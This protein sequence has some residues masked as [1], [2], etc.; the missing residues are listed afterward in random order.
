MAV[1]VTHV[2]WSVELGKPPS[3][4]RSLTTIDVLRHKREVSAENWGV[5]TRTHAR[6]TLNSCSAHTL[7]VL[8]VHIGCEFHIIQLIK[9]DK[10]LNDVSDWLVFSL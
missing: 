2:E 6:H 9:W 8:T 7:Q 10:F 4:S 5:C 3:R 1:T